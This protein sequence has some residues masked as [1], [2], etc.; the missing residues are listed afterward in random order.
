MRSYRS[1]PEGTHIIMKNIYRIVSALALVAM[2]IGC[3][4]DGGNQAN[5]TQKDT[6]PP[7]QRIKIG[8]TKEEVRQALGNPGGVATSSQ[9]LE[10]WTYKD[11]A[12]A[13]IP[14]YAISGGKFQFLRINFDADGKVK[15]W[16]S[17]SQSA[18]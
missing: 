15:D 17:D 4:S 14:F 13:F 11:T 10:T 1:R 18:F 3:A 16:S 6:R 9:G 5:N 2:L 7:E 8:M 12:K